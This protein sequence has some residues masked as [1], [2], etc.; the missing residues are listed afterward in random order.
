MAATPEPTSILD[1]SAA[2]ARRTPS[3]EARQSEPRDIRCTRG[4]FELL[5]SREELR[6]VYAPADQLAETLRWSA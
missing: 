6:G 2:R 1:R 4:V 3:Q 5:E